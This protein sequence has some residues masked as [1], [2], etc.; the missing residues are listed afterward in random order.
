M[1]V[2]RDV[3][4]PEDGLCGCVH[5]PMSTIEHFAQGVDS[6]CGHVIQPVARPIARALAAR[7]D[8][9]GGEQTRVVAFAVMRIAKFGVIQPVISQTGLE[10]RVQLAVAVNVTAVVVGFIKHFVVFSGHQHHEW[11]GRDLC[12]QWG[13]GYGHRARC[14]GRQR[15]DS[16]CCVFEHL[17]KVLVAHGFSLKKKGADDYSVA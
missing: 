16:K 2:L 6:T 3:G 10:T 15:R 7:S 4:T 11:F 1:R 14:H 8:R 13:V 5:F 12:D 17:L 9:S